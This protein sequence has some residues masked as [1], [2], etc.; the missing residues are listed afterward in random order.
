MLMKE[1]LLVFSLLALCFSSCSKD[2]HIDKE[3]SMILTVAEESGNALKGAVILLYDNYHDWYE[4][5]NA[6][7]AGLTDENGEVLFEDLDEAIYYFDAYH[8]ETYWNYPLGIYR[9]EN[10]LQKGVLKKIAVVLYE[11]NTD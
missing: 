7:R 5:T 2:E 8:S 3:P 9:T 11:Y 10:P 1:K 6:V 4:G